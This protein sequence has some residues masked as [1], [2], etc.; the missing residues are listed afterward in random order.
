M[1]RNTTHLLLACRTGDGRCWGELLEQVRTLAF[2]TAL[3]QYRLALEDAEDLAQ[4]V[5]VRVAERSDQLHCDAAFR[6]WVRQLVHRSAIDT[7]RRQKPAVS[8]DDPELQAD[9]IPE[10]R[11]PYAHVLLSMELSGALASLP[12]RYRQPIQLHVLAG[13]SQDEVGLVLGRNRS[14]VATQIERGLTRLRQTLQ[15]AV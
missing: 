10:P 12:E 6:S 15:A 9:G 2:R 1:E 8:L 3:F 11:D 7:L 5:Q 13:L 4:V 14:T